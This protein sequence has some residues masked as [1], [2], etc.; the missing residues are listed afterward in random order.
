MEIIKNTICKDKL[1]NNSNIS[2]NVCFFD[3]E[4]T[5]FNRDN[6]II[7]L[8]GILYFDN[9]KN[10]WMLV[11]YLA[12]NLNDEFDLLIESSKFLM[13]FETLINYNG[14]SFDIPFINH[15]LK[16]YNI[17]FAIDKTRSLDLYSI[18]RRNKDILN[19]DNLKLKTVEEYLGIN[20]EDIYTGKDCIDFYKNYTLS[21]D[22]QLKDKLLK[23]NYDDLYYLVDIM[24]VL[25]IIKRKK[26]FKVNRSNHTIEFLISNI[27]E[28]KDS[29]IFE[30]SVNGLREKLIYYDT[31]FNI[32]IEDI[33]Q[34]KIIIYTSQGLLTPS[35][36]CTFINLSDFNISVDLPSSHGYR[37][38]RDIFIL[39]IESRYV[40]DDV[41]KLLKEIIDTII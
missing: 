9:E 28:V 35:K 34:F 41:L 37:I 6:D 40:L 16:L 15:K 25:N 3:I 33:N 13:N 11:Q 32:L 31:S 10:S 2:N 26:S 27:S 18:I 36:T 22:L 8:I 12:N 21:G 4:T 24:D 14:N 19:M 38:P 17:P 7:Y 39:K 5:G 29:L 1:Y 30:G 23:H 20:R